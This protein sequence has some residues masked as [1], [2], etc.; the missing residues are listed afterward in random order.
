MTGCFKEICF[1]QA[2]ELTLSSQSQTI[3]FDHAA[4]QNARL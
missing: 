2:G 1:A 3:I 4:P